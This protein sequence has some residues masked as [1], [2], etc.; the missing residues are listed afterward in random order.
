MCY[1]VLNKTR[2]GVKYMEVM[3]QVFFKVDE[4]GQVYIDFD[5]LAEVGVAV[6]VV[7]DQIDMILW[8]KK[9]TLDGFYVNR[10]SREFVILF[11]SVASNTG[12]ILQDCVVVPFGSRDY[13]VLPHDI[14]VRGE[15]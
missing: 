7:R 13:S 9:Y 8:S 12:A 4:N 11:S 15:F 6:D 14:Y 5:A 1:N 2:K 3:E 10:R